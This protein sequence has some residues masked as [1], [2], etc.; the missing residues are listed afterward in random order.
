M[1]SPLTING[2][3]GWAISADWFQA[4][5]TSVVP[6]AKVQTFY[7]QYPDS[8]DEA[9]QFISTHPANLWIGYSLGS[10]WLLR[11]A[12]L[13]SPASSLA[14][15]SPVFGFTQEMR[16]G[17]KIRTVQLNYIIR[18]LQRKPDDLQSVLEF[19]KE[20]GIDPQHA[21]FELSIS[22][23]VLV[24]GLCF[25]RDHSFNSEIRN[26]YFSAVGEQDHLIDCKS[27]KREIPDLVIVPGT[28]HHPLPLL[29]ALAKSF[30]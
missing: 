23:E 21:E 18:N 11:Y 20:T 29:K 27:L 12:H 13:I 15:L 7:P 2:I 28:G 5:I 14:L 3:C 16:R 22:P 9:R 1:R 19:L 25:L 30:V 26:P 4:Q 17:G 8:L 24:R 10:L 6:D